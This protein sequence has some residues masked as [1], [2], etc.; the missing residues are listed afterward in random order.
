M[1]Y[2]NI[3]KYTP[4]YLTGYTGPKPVIPNE[5][6]SAPHLTNMGYVR[7][8][9]KN[10]GLYMGYNCS[11]ME[12]FNCPLNY[13]KT[14]WNKCEEIGTYV[15]EPYI[16][17]MNPPAVFRPNRP[18]PN[19]LPIHITHVVTMHKKLQCNNTHVHL[20]AQSHCVLTLFTI[21]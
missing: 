15:L 5:T 11:F 4:I 1:T 14:V 10:F 18:N 12:G 9:V 17:E 19:A 21:T 13:V 8:I 3:P 16:C 7:P 2:L 6:A 20:V